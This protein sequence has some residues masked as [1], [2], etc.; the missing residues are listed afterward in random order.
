MN[1]VALDGTTQGRR[2]SLLEM[3]LLF[4]LWARYAVGGGGLLC[5]NSRD[6]GKEPAVSC[7]EWVLQ[8]L[9]NE[10][11]LRERDDLRTE[12]GAR[13]E[14]IHPGNWNLEAGPDFL[15][16]VLRLDGVRRRGDVEI[17]RCP[18]DWRAH[19]HD[20]DPRY[21]KVIMHVVWEPGRSSAS[22]GLPPCLAMKN[23]LSP[24]WLRLLSEAAAE[25]YPYSRKVA[26][27]QCALQTARLEDAVVREFLTA[28]GLHRFRIKS[29][30]ILDRAL[31]V[32]FPQTAYEAFWEALGYKANSQAFQSLARALPLARLRE[33][34]EP[35]SRLAA[36]LGSSG[37]LVDPTRRADR[38][39]IP[40]PSLNQEL[41][42]RWWKLGLPPLSP[43]W[44]RH[45]MRPANRPER[46]LPVGWS[47]LEKWHYQP[48]E[49][50]SRGLPPEADP[51]SLVRALQAL[52]D[53]SPTSEFTR[54]L[55]LNNAPSASLGQH[56]TLDLAVNAVLPLLHARA[57]QDRETAR[58]QWA[59]SAFLNLPKL[60][61]NRVSK[62]ITHRL[63]VPASR[64]REIVKGAAQQQGLLA[65][66]WDFCRQ[67]ANNCEICPLTNREMF[68]KCLV[69]S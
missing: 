62:Q 19:G 61:E 5:E 56:R 17:H 55:A 54:V 42:H 21:D 33:I 28:A 38:S 12:D 13:V 6:T 59:E 7:A 51:N 64:R 43:S 22:E 11:Y 48:V 4:T 29:R 68:E 45:G 37:F 50:W 16:A 65:V 24:Q 60:Q 31:A 58:Q 35:S 14:I 66:A 20:V 3:Y 2:E 53:F 36:L 1:T 32:G 69:A 25:G 67:M 44:R 15:D 49:A 27:G 30:R 40:H 41:W 8:A 46:R 57:C 52:F 9:W 10:S 26:P 63:L 47:L 34:K 18:G 39:R 23:Y